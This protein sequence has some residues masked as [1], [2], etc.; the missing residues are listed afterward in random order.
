ME[1]RLHVN[2]GITGGHMNSIDDYCRIYHNRM[3][4]M[5]HEQADTVEVRPSRA[6][7]P[8]GKYPLTPSPMGIV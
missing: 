3:Y 8:G 4:H 7:D 6:R 5:R 1:E 2:F